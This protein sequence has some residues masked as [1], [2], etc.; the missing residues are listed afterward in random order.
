MWENKPNVDHPSVYWP[1]IEG[2]SRVHLPDQF[3]WSDW[4]DIET[5]GLL[6]EF[7]IE[8]RQQEHVDGPFAHQSY[9]LESSSD[10]GPFLFEIAYSLIAFPFTCLCMQSH[11]KAE[12]A[13]GRHCL[14]T[15]KSNRRPG[16]EG[17]ITRRFHE[18][19]DS[20]YFEKRFIE[21]LKSMDRK[22]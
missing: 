6:K 2:I 13:A 7:M 14:K 5:L 22:C 9:N 21:R 17:R 10:P 16:K 4:E 8:V 15:P 19:L 18:A 3:V 1:H 12:N 20:Q 11:A